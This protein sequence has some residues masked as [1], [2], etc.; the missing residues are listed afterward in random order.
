[1]DAAHERE[2]RRFQRSIAEI[3]DPEMWAEQPLSV[4]I[5]RALQLFFSRLEGRQRL[6]AAFLESAAR[7]P[8]QWRHAVEFRQMVVQSF[9]ELLALREDEIRHPDP[10]RAI[11]FAIHQVLALVDQRALFAHVNG[12]E[13]ADLSDE[14]LR[15]ELTRS[16]RRYLGVDSE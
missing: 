1:M 2:Q 4:M 8:K 9:G 7:K 5:E 16:L 14:E 10:P 6:A 15:D 12:P 11:R 3:V 13:S